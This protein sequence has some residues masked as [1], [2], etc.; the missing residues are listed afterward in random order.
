MRLDTH[1]EGARADDA[2]DVLG[3][4]ARHHLPGHGLREH[5]VTTLAARQ[6]G[7]TVEPGGLSRHEEHRRHTR[8]GARRQGA[9]VACER[10]VHVER[11]N[12]HLR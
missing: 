5:L 2:E 3:L 8:I 12:Q 10:H 1:I 11:Q 9:L 4:L 7:E 6:H